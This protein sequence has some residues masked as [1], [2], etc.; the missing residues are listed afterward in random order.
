MIGGK[1]FFSSWERARDGGSGETIRAGWGWWGGNGV[2]LLMVAIAGTL[3]E[4]MPS[5]CM[6]Y[7]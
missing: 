2:V 4:L 5:S 6:L 1:W 7:L 3:I